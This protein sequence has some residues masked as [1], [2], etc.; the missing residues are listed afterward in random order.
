MHMTI[1]RVPSHPVGLGPLGGPMRLILA[2]AFLLALPSIADAGSVV[3]P[4]YGCQTKEDFK[5]IWPDV[6]PV[7]VGRE[8]QD[9]I[10]TLL[11][12]DRCRKFDAGEKVLIQK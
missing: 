5:R 6:R 7:D 12:A 10:N 1:L 3:L 9:L 8:R 2:L 11:E 4:V